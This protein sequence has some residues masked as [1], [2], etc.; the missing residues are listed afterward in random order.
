M[1]FLVMLRC[2]QVP[3]SSPQ[4]VILCVYLAAFH[5][6][7]GYLYIKNALLRCRYADAP[8]CRFRVAKPIP[9]RSSGSGRICRP[10][11]P[12]SLQWHFA[13]GQPLQ[14]RVRAGFSPVFPLSSPFLGGTW[15]MFILFSTLSLRAPFVNL[16]Q[17]F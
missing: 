14:R 3:F 16:Y 4:R 7:C 13:A 2:R 6:F 15:N 11:L 9:C 17:L 12:K 8:S 5:A 10:R 1:L